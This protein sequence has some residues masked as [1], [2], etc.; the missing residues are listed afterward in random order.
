M[1]SWR[2]GSPA[3]VA[4]SVDERGGPRVE[5]RLEACIKIDGVWWRCWIRDL[6]PGGAGL[7]PAIPSALGKMVELTG[8]LF[9]RVGPMRGRV[10]NLAGQRT[11]V[12]FELDREQEEQL[13]QTIVANT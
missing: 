11:C 9:D 8:P 13:R 10:V 5:G 4:A 1:T 7:E 6:S 12:A 2:G 3:G